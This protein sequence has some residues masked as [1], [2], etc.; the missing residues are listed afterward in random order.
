M[1]RPGVNQLLVEFLR[2]FVVHGV[3]VIGPIVIVARCFKF[4]TFA[5]GEQI[6]N[7]ARQSGT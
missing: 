4:W 5:T 1:L 6:S 2:L 3:E 7:T